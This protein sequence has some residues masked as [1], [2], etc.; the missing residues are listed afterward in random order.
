MEQHQS[1]P[2]YK[3]NELSYFGFFVIN[4]VLGSWE[5]Q[6]AKGNLLGSCVTT[7]HQQE[8]DS[9]VLFDS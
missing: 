7:L 3:H 1:V 9:L 2:Q 6:L 8:L 5:K 4:V